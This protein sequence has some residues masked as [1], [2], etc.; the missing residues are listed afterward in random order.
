MATF[1]LDPAF[2][3]EAVF[4][5]SYLTFECRMGQGNMVSGQTY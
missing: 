1:V 2:G 5:R 4:S 3:K